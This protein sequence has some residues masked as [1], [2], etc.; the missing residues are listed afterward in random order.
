MARTKKAMLDTT[1]VC[2]KC[3][4]EQE[5]NK[6]LSS[7]NFNVYE[8]VPCKCGGNFKPR[9]MIEEEQNRCDTTR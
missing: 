9:F 8:C 6:K 4:A 2:E 5:L 7:P 3:G 1:P